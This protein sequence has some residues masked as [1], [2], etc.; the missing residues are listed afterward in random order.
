MGYKRLVQYGWD[1]SDIPAS[2]DIFW[3]DDGEFAIVFHAVDE[4]PNLSSGERIVIDNTNEAYRFDGYEDCDFTST[5]VLKDS[6][7]KTGYANV[8]GRFA[9]PL[10][11]CI[12]DALKDLGV[13]D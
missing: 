11:V 12:Q 2:V 8:R 5:T 9:Y 7:S 13:F 10:L 4:S 1:V 3:G 6:K